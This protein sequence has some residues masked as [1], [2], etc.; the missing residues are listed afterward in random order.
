MPH[1][2]RVL[3][4]E[5]GTEYIDSFSRFLPDS[6]AFSRAGSGPEALAALAQANASGAPYHA[7]IL[8][9]RF[10]RSPQ[11][12]LLGD[13]AQAAERFNGDP[14][15]ARRFLEDH[16]GN[17]ILAALRAAG[18][19]LPVLFSHD[20]SG[21]PRRWERLVQKYAPL[22]YLPDS[23]SPADVERALLSL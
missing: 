9:M 21:E 4:I 18:H 17:Y 23:A 15:K 1:P 14:V 8:D 20:F 19:T 5:D 22:R 16:Q 6:F 13:L 11:P 10:D 2:L 12:S 3:V 7:A